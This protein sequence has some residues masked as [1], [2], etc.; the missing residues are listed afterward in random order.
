VVELF[1][2]TSEKLAV[3]LSYDVVF[4]NLN[5]DVQNIYQYDPANEN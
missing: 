3:R 5:Q 1:H 4:K 2:S